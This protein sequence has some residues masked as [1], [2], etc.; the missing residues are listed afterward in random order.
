MAAQWALYPKLQDALYLPADLW[1]GLLLD[2][3]QEGSHAFLPCCFC[4]P[5]T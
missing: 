1:V 4:L 2:M 3:L 5:F